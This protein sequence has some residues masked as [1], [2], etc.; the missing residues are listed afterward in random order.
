MFA[1]SRI[2]GPVVAS[3]PASGT[4]LAV[5]AYH[6]GMDP[7]LYADQAIREALADG[8]L[9]ASDHAGRPLPKMLPNDDGWWI[10]SFLEREN[11]PDRYSEAKRLADD[12]LGRAVGAPTLEQA[13]AILSARTA[14][15][16]AWNSSA[17]ETHHLPMVDEP[18]LIAL[19][20]DL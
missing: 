10:R 4:C 6:H 12:L 2:H 7:Q 14:G 3:H 19:R 13:R 16:D 9:N 18:D 8:S 20:H 11:L 17:P 1:Y 15:V 5:D